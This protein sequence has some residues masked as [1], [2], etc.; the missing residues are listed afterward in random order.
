MH[1]GN[2]TIPSWFFFAS[3]FIYL[4]T[5]S[6]QDLIIQLVMIYQSLTFVFELSNLV[7]FSYLKVHHLPTSH[8]WIIKEYKLFF[9]RIWFN[10]IF[11]INLMFQ[12]RIQPGCTGCTCTPLVS[13]YMSI[14]SVLNARSTL[15]VWA[16]QGC[17]LNI[18]KLNTGC[19]LNATEYR[20]HNKF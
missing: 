15:N 8:W 19:N 20:V 3:F 7:K 13:E 14:Y 2:N 18:I 11:N 12:G 9:T 6:F 5:S 16:N 1:Y 4:F 10:N 17:T